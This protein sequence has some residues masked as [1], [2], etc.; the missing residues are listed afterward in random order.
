MTY[1][2]YSIFQQEKKMKNINKNTN[3][4]YNKSLLD[5]KNIVFSKLSSLIFPLFLNS[6]APLTLNTLSTAALKVSGVLYCT[7]TFFRVGMEFKTNK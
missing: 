7:N 5:F 4:K 1:A 3:I 6:T 2:Y